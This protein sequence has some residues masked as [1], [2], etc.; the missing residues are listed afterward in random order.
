[1]FQGGN[2]W[3]S[4]FSPFFRFLLPQNLPTD[5]FLGQKYLVIAIGD[6]G[7]HLHEAC[8]HSKVILFVCFVI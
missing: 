5:I 2:I 3:V 7:S 1:M 4:V 6:S 8:Y